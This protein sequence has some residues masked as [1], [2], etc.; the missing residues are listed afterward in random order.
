MSP[1][2]PFPQRLTGSAKELGD[3]KALE[4]RTLRRLWVRIKHPVHG[5][6]ALDAREQKEEAEYVAALTAEQTAAARTSVLEGQ[7]R[8]LAA[9]VDELHGPVDAYKRAR[10][11]LAALYARV[12]DGPTPGFPEED[13]LEGAFR[14]AL[15]AYDAAQGAT[16][17]EQR[18]T[19]CLQQA[20]QHLQ[21]AVQIVAGSTD[22]A[23]MNAYGGTDD[24]ALVEHSEL[25]GA[26]REVDQARLL[27]E[28]AQALLPGLPG[29]GAVQMPKGW[30]GV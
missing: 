11:E 17:N 28:Q 14:A 18:A 21:K 26:Q 25:A 4:Q 9:R 23:T 5:R 27:V 13:A 7:V 22:Y 10:R 20:D 1:P 15:D 8:E 19:T 16:V 3:W 12:F 24:V 30:V 6:E 29:L 2:F